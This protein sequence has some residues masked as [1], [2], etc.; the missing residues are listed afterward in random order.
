M[1]KLKLFSHD[2][3]NHFTLWITTKRSRISRTMA[4]LIIIITSAFKKW[5]ISQVGLRLASPQS[6]FLGCSCWCV[7]QPRVSIPE[8]CNDEKYADERCLR[9]H[10]NRLSHI[11]GKNVSDTSLLVK[12]LT[13]CRQKYTS[14]CM[15]SWN[16]PDQE[17]LSFWSAYVKGGPHTTTNESSCFASH[18]EVHCK[19]TLP[20]PC[21]C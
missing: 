21:L 4:I 3:T 8:S 17:P 12:I 20:P 14:Q 10:G 13:C 15:W 11:H 18:E 2:T 9:G 6:H 1:K 19:K 7:P 16:S 5:P